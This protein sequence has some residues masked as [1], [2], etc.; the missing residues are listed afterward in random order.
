VREL[1]ARASAD[2]A[3]SV[4]A[5]TALLRDVEGYPRWYPE[6]VRTV[7]ALERGADAT[8][9]RVRATLHLAQGPLQRDFQLTLAVSEPGGGVIV[10]ERERHSPSD[11]ERLAVTWRVQEGQISLILDAVLDVP[12]LLPLGGLGESLAR[13]FVAAAARALAREL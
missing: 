11:P 1:H 12:R 10:L 6:G 4:E 5:A 8:A 7:Q 3:A 9:S 13:G 2:T